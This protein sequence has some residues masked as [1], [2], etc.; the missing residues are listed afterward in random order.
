MRKHEVR[1][2]K[3]LAGAPKTSPEVQA[4]VESYRTAEG[5][6]ERHDAYDALV[7]TIGKAAPND[8]DPTNPL[9][10]KFMDEVA[11]AINRR[12][13]AEKQFSVEA[14][15]YHSFLESWRGRIAKMFSAHGAGDLSQVAEK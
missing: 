8:V 1:L 9:D 14:G 6:R 3:A 7:A 4:A 15:A 12:Q 2:T 10:R 13:I 5:S 11:G